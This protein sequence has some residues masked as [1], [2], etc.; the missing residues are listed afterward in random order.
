ME[1]AQIEAFLVLAE[2]LH[3]GRTSARLHVSQ[4]MVSRRIADL[5]REIGGQIFER[6]SRQVRLTPLGAIFL[7]SLRPAF[8]QVDTAFREAR[9]AARQPAGVVTVGFTAST[10]GPVVT[11]LIN[12]Y[13]CEYPGSEVRLEQV[14]IMDPYTGLRSGRID[15]LVNW[16]AGGEADLTFGP[17][18][19][20]QERVL[21]VA[22]RHPLAR[23][24]SVSVEDLA[25]L[26]VFDTPPTF[27]R[28]LWHAMVP[29][30]TPSGRPIPRTVMVNDLSEM[31]AQVALGQIVHPTVTSVGRTIRDDIV[32]VPIVDMLPLPLG[33]IWCSAHENARIRA[34]AATAKTATPI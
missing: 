17:E 5:E 15:V 9:A 6:T 30:E 31:W 1:I 25:G 4:P 34:L 20:R 28:S 29:P 32:L 27:P 18:L 33:L 21:A 3:F 8:A 19:D 10:E 16:L 13:R 12:A 24:R 23:H 11:R 7:E 26:P 22:K 14:S 2:E